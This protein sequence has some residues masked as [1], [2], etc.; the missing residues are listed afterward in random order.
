[1]RL[2][3]PSDLKAIYR[4]FAVL[5]GQMFPHVRQDA[6]ERRIRAKECVFDSDVVLVFQRYKKRTRVGDVDIPAGSVMLHQ[7]VNGNQFNGAGGR[8]FDRFHDEMAADLYLSVRAENT[9]ARRFYERHGMKA[10]GKVSWAGDAKGV[11]YCKSTRQQSTEH[12]SCVEALFSHYRASGFPV[13]DLAPRE[14]AERLAALMAFDYSTI[15]RDSVIRQTMHA[16]GLCWHF[17]PHMWDIQ[18]AGKKTPMEVFLD[19]RLFRQALAKRLAMGTYVTDG[20]VRKALSNFSGTQRVSTFRPTAAAAIYRE[21]LPTKGGTT[22]DFSGGFGG[23]LLGALACQRVKRYVATEPSTMTME[24]LECMA[25]ELVPMSGRRIGVELHRLGSEDFLPDRNS[26]DLV[27]SSGPYF[28]NELY[29]NEPSQSFIKFPTRHE[30]LEGYMGGTLANCR[31]GLKRGG[32]LAVNIA[33]VPS[34]PRL[35]AEFLKLAK[36][37]GWILRATFRIEMSRMVGTRIHNGGSAVKTEPLFIF[38]KT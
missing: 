27:F 26:L 31:R 3:E 14:R 12:H 28:R 32:L 7:I 15:I 22:W 6:L 4:M 29:A 9:I 2:A 35:E 1:M 13:Y 20:G 19:D 34:Y 11:I 18:C 24:G 21:L 23:R 33:G 38:I 17:H 25:S 10:V 16:V 37:E 8:L 36:R 5:R 30:W